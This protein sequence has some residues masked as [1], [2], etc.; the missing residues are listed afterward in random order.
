MGEKLA[1]LAGAERSRRASDA[2]EV[3]FDR[4]H[5]ARILELVADK[6]DRQED[7]IASTRCSTPMRTLLAEI[8]AL[9]STRTRYSAD[10]GQV[11]SA[12]LARR[13]GR[14]AS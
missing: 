12:V 5:S 3:G 14:P 4:I 11:V 13:I 9:G 7:W 2:A 6:A 1:Q 10:A 8:S